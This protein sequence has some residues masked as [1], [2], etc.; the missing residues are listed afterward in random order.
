MKAEYIKDK[1]DDV[2]CDIWDR[3]PDDDCTC[4]QCREMAN[5]KSEDEE[6]E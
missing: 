2:H 5:Q 1:R 3:C 6:N 4:T